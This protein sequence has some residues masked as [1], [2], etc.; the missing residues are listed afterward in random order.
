MISFSEARSTSV[1]KSLKPLSLMV[2]DPISSDALVMIE[3]ARRA[4]LTAIFKVGCVINL[5]N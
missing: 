4:A 1:T 3:P 2:K 5:K